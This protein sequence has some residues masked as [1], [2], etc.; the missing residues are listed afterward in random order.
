MLT[1][2]DLKI[3][4][5]NLSKSKKRRE[6]IQSSFKEY[7][8]IKIS[9]IDGFSKFS[10]KEYDRFERPIWKEIEKEKLIKEKTLSDNYRRYYDLIPTEVGCNLSHIK[11]WTHFLKT[12]EEYSIFI[13]DDVIPKRSLK[14]IE[15]PDDFG[16]FYL[17]DKTHPGNR[18]SVYNDGQVKWARTFM[19]YILS[20]KSAK[21]CL[22][23]AFPFYY[24][25]DLQI[26]LRLF[27]SYKS[28]MRKK[29]PHWKEL[30]RFKAYATNN[31]YV[32]H[33]EE[34]KKTTFTK[35]GK[36]NWLLKED[37]IL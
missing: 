24:Q 30:S 34:A 19:G 16:I 21:L 36:K 1:L 3:R 17:T 23:A 35:T 18:M 29:I 14:E 37:Q 5:I 33:S 10:T 26:P 28:Y 8:L 25:T 4:Y 32:I 2:K 15:V 13:E 22:E 12:E 6:A 20:R 11:A 7:S 31:S 9:A 27:E